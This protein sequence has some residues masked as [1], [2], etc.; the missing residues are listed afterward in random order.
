MVGL[1]EDITC[2]FNGNSRLAATAA[3]AMTRKI[4]VD[5]RLFTSHTI[6]G[7]FYHKHVYSHVG[8]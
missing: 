2:Y 3:C 8:C 4:A 1:R 7:N 5:Q 6:V